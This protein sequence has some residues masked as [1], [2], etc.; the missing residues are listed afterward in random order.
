MEVLEPGLCPFRHVRRIIEA[1]DRY[2]V[3][4]LDGFDRADLVAAA[5]LADAGG[6]RRFWSSTPP[7]R[8]ATPWPYER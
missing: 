5:A 7:G 1:A 4:V 2:R 6:P 8:A 3:L